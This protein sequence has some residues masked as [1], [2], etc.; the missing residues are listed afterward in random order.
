MFLRLER[1]ALLAAALALAPASPAADAAAL[2]WTPVQ[3]STAAPL[4]SSDARVE[5]VREAVLAAQVAGSIT[6]LQVHAGASVKAGQEL[7]RIDARMASQGAAASSAQVVAA[8]AQASVAA[9]DYERQQ[10]LFARHYI[11]QAALEQARARWQASQAQVKALQAQAAV[12]GTQTGLHV[13]RAP[14]D[15]VVASVPVTLG[16]MALPGKPLLTLVD[17]GALRI[18]AALSQAQT[19]RLRGAPQVMVE[20]PGAGTPPT[21]IAMAQVQVLPT[22]DAQSHTSTVRVLLPAGLA[23]A[24]PGAFA[25]L[26]FEGAGA[27]GNPTRLFVPA[28]SVVRRAE[29]SGVYVRAGDGKPRLRQVRL[30]PAAGE[31]I[32]VLSGLSAGEQVATDPQAAAR[33]R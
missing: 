13:L 32:E 14:F 3:T 30:G 25:R 1:I 29:M 5:A 11:S 20:L 9:R 10:Q 22:A 31:Q 28:A 24:V 19:A 23:G 33:E 15:G 6:A 18:T 2:G 8:Q 26:W 4:Q 16:D 21:T 12:A 7:L 27:A 17:P